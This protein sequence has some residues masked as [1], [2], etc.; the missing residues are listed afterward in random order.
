[1]VKPVSRFPQPIQKKQVA[2]D[3]TEVVYNFNV[4]PGRVAFIFLVGAQLP[5]KARVKWIVDGETVKPG[6]EHIKVG[7][8]HNPGKVNPPI[9]AEDQVKWQ[10]YSPEDYQC[11][12]LVDGEVYDLPVTRRTVTKAVEAALESN[13]EPKPQ[14]KT[15]TEIIDLKNVEVDGTWEICHV[16]EAGYLHELLIVTDTTEFTLV[17]D[18]DDKRYQGDYSDY[19]SYSQYIDEVV[20]LESDGNY[21]I[22]LAKMYFSK[23]FRAFVR[24]SLT[25]S[26][27]FCKY[28]VEENE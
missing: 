24:G 14:S 19:S 17:T 6:E 26:K 11:I 20:A 2:A 16:E 15:T 10:V 7:S 3:S 28:Q 27:V 4:D 18:L 12:V 23:G 21:R 5:E 9:V 8:I 25:L 22:H 1:M 13:S